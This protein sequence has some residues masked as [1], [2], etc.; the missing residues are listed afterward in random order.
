MIEYPDGAEK[1][2]G[3]NS[4]TKTSANEGTER[5]KQISTGSHDIATTKTEEK[6]KMLKQVR[7][8]I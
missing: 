5:E 1:D 8:P 2:S 7:K 3:I 4:S 6:E